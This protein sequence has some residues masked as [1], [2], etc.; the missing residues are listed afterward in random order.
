M[1]ILRFFFW[2]YIEN[3]DVYLINSERGI[4]G[5]KCFD[6]LKKRKNIDIWNYW[7]RNENWLLIFLVWDKV[8][9]VEIE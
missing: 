9:S 7:C 4:K 3:F 5:D 2:G 8:C 1:W 6:I